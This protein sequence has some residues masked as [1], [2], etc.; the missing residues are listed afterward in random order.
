MG[1][2]LG[3]VDD[4]RWNAYSRKM[5]AYTAARALAEARTMSATELGAHGI[6]V[7]QDGQRRSLFSLLSLSDLDPAQ[8]VA[9]DPELAAADPATLWQLRTDSLYAQY[10]DRQ[11]REAAALRR[12]E[13]VVIPNDMD[14]TTL[15]G[16]SNELRQ[17]LAHARPAT[18]AQAARI[19]GMTPAA[20]ALL[21]ALVRRNG[22]RATA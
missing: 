4:E 6:A 8:V 1:R 12:E 18:I 3:L 14:F 19:E 5:R 22:K 11:Q 10:T 2:E 21:L 15:S 7:R 13:A 9:L 17:K 16:L 20:L